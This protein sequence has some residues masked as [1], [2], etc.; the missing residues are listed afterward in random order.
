MPAALQSYKGTTLYVDH[1]SRQEMEQMI[2][3]FGQTSRIT[4]RTKRVL[5]SLSFQRQVK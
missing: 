5:T 4:I 3:D 2:A 1:L